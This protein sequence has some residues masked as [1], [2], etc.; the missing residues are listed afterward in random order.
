MRDIFV[1]AAVFIAAL[2]GFRR[3]V[4]GMM[5]FAFLGFFSPQSY[6]WSFARTF[7]LSQVIAIS[8]ILGMFLSRE[9]NRLPLQRETILLILLWV[10]FAVSTL[11]ALYPADAFERFV[12]MSKIL[13]MVVV[14]MAVI[15]SEERLHAFIRI[16][17]FSLGF[18]GIKGGLFAILSGGGFLVYGPEISFLAANNSIGLAL[19]MN[20]PMLLYLLKNEELA[21]VRWIVR[22][23]LLF[24][25]PAIICTYSRGAWLG[26]VMVTALSVLNSRRKFLVVPLAGALAV[27][28]QSVVPEIT[29]N[30]LAQR[31]DS[32][33][34]YEED[35]SAQS[36]FWNWEFCK[37]V[38]LARPLTG[39]GF[40]FYTLESYA[41]FYPEF[42]ERWP[43]KVWSCH[44]TWLTIFGEH[45]FPGAILWLLLVSCCLLSLRQIW[46]YGGMT[47][48]KSQYAFFADMAQSSIVTYLVIGTFLDAAYFD[49]FYYFVCFVVVTKGIM[50]VEV[51]KAATVVRP[52]NAP[53]TRPVKAR[54]EPSHPN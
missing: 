11:F 45:G 13:L 53:M 47:P 6:T 27:V 38:G 25:Y 23:M 26:L 32:L 15:N 22:A 33:V 37:R 42:M 52:M 3:P 16:I 39:G 43:G 7:P 10:S 5:T 35:S 51:G 44:S 34:N 28:L 50:A 2:I 40:N 21:W 48:G 24:S 19:A 18:Y 12:K 4:F 14:A 41:R 46:A 54:L 30:R 31:Y 20:I 36:R 29:P 17:G 9:R 1:V 8:T 49:L